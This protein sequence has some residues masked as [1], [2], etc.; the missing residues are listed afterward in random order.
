MK[1][2]SYLLVW[3]LNLSIVDRVYNVM[4]RLA[5]NRA[6]NALRCPENFFYTTGQIF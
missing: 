4:R 5:I 2:T 6:P 3:H 1:Y